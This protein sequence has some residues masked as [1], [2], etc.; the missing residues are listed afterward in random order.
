MEEIPARK[1]KRNVRKIEMENKVEINAKYR[2]YK[3]NEYVVLCIA[4]H[5]ETEEKMVVYKALYGDEKVWVRPL[6]MWNEEVEVDGNSVRRF[7]R[8]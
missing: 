3:G 7:K 1:I 8:I 2:H 6:S 5:S 4:T